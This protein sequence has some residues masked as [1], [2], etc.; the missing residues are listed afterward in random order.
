MR[1]IA[2]LIF[3]FVFLFIVSLIYAGCST[4]GSA[5]VL[6]LENGKT[7]IIGTGDNEPKATIAA[8]DEAQAYC[9]KSELNPVFNDQAIFALNQKKKKGFDLKKMP[10]VGQ[11]FNSDAP[12]RVVVEFRCA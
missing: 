7:R 2:R 5:R 12:A 3:A 1:T 6:K 9:D 4:S 11:A 10:F 8:I